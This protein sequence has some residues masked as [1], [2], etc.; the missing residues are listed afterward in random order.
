M[1]GFVTGLVVDIA[2]KTGG[3]GLGL[4][5]SA[6]FGGIT[7]GASSAV[8]QLVNKVTIDIGDVIIDTAFGAIGG[9]LTFGFAGGGFPGAGEYLKQIFSLPLKSLFQKTAYDL[10]TS[11][12]V[13][14]F[15]W[16]GGLGMKYAKSNA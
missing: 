5:L 15:S 14:A 4:L 11:L 8:N 7:S 3:L 10:T 16:L 1:V 13:S 9:I 6:G 2:V 12:I